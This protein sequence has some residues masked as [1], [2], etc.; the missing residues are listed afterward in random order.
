MCETMMRIG[1]PKEESK[2]YIS[3]IAEIIRPMNP[4]VIYLENTDIAASVEKAAKERPGWLDA[5]IDYHVNGMYGKAMG[6]E[7]FDGYIRCLEE[8]QR[9][10]L[11][12][13]AGLPVEYLVISNP[14][15]DWEAAQEKIREYI[16]RNTGNC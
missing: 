3:E 13:L 12:I 15:K 16:Y 8:R 2:R 6:A 11:R 7:G 9:R 4:V 10:E 1:F 5:V 14:Q